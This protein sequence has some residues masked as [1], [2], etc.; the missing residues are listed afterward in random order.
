MIRIAMLI[1]RVLANVERESVLAEV[2]MK[3]NRMM[4]G[5]PLFAW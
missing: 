5:L 3:V 2:K 1:D 4:E